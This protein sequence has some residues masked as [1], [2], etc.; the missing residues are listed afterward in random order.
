MVKVAECEG[1]GESEEKEEQKGKVVVVL[2]SCA[3]MYCNKGGGCAEVGF[4]F[5]LRV[6]SSK[7]G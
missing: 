2:Y 4:R 3:L 6:S 1:E 7:K 5:K